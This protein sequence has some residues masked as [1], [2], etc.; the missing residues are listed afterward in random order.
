MGAKGSKPF[1]ES[2]TK[3]R[4]MQ[5]IKS[6]LRKSRKA[7]VVD[8]AVDGHPAEEK[9]VHRDDSTCDRR[10]TTGPRGLSIDETQP[11]FS[12]ELLQLFSDNINSLS[13]SIEHKFLAGEDE[14]KYQCR[15]LNRDSLHG[16]IPRMDDFESEGKEVYFGSVGT[17][18]AQIYPYITT[19]ERDAATLDGKPKA[20]SALMGMMIGV[21]MDKSRCTLDASFSQFRGN[22]SKPALYMTNNIGF[23]IGA[24]TDYA[25]VNEYPM[26]EVYTKDEN[27]AFTKTIDDDFTELAKLDAENWDGK[28]TIRLYNPGKPKPGAT[29]L[30]TEELRKKQ[31][32]QESNLKAIIEL[33]KPYFYPLIIVNH[34]HYNKVY[35]TKW[36]VSYAADL[37]ASDTYSGKDEIIFVDYGG[38]GPSVSLYKRLRDGNDEWVKDVTPKIAKGLQAKLSSSMKKQVD[39]A[40]QWN[41]ELETA[42][43]AQ[44]EETI[45]ATSLEIVEGLKVLRSDLGVNEDVPIIVRQTGMLRSC[46]YGD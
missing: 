44:I 29:R 34:M 21:D 5:K 22:E 7:E 13:D 12:K 2:K 19:G 17:T 25:V 14:L 1:N 30:S 20:T 36:R 8:A 32:Q 15:T 16:K 4:F 24:E 27:G 39:F 31:C 28:S 18:S 6:K 9:S 42:D 41:Q 23:L 38:G 3:V 46:Y 40:K 37:F 43:H 26:V 33:V 10:T 45:I 11:K 35:N